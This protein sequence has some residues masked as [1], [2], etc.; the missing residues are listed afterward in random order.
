MQ[1]IKQYELFE[2]AD[3]MRRFVR[4]GKMA[5]VKQKGFGNDTFHAPPTSRGFYAMPLKYQELF[6]VGSLDKYQPDQ[7]NV[8]KRPDYQTA[9]AE[10]YDEWEKKYKKW[11]SGVRHEFTVSPTEEL[12]HH[13]RTPNNEVLARSGSWVK[14]TFNAWKK[15]VDKERMQLRGESMEQ[16]RKDIDAGYEI[17][18]PNINS[19]PKK[20]GYYSKDQFEVFFDH[21][22]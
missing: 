6:L 8:T 22:I 13:L 7:Y 20:T 15:A 5:P 4:F 11:F 9:T 12:W 17:K 1:Y 14:T 19:V 16:I 21:K 2:G 3:E 18:K 10:D